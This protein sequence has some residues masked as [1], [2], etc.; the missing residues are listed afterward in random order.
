MKKY[1]FYPLILIIL[2]IMSGCG[3]PTAPASTTST[4][5]SLK[6][7]TTTV[8]GTVEQSAFIQSAYGSDHGTISDAGYLEFVWYYDLSSEIFK[9]VYIRFHLPSIPAGATIESATLDFYVSTFE[10]TCSTTI[11]QVNSSWDKTTI[12]STNEPTAGPFVNSKDSVL[13]WNKIYVT[14]LVRG[15][16]AGTIANNGVII[17]PNAYYYASNMNHFMDYNDSQNYPRISVYYR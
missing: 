4:T 3:D 7:P 5:P 9:K 17:F 1:F 14:S 15:W 10:A 11:T 12:A 13:G 6:P 2:V 16:I 8:I